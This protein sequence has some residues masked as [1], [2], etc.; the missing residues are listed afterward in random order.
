MRREEV[1]ERHVVDWLAASNERRNRKDVV[2][3]LAATDQ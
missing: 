2:D 3:R 1:S